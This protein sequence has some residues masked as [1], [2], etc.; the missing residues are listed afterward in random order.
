MFRRNLRTG[1]TDSPQTAVPLYEA[2]WCYIS[3]FRDQ[4]QVE[5]GGGGGG[6]RMGSR[7]MRS[8]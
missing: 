5:E 3:N 1:A 4:E 8:R 7:R 2:T 6:R